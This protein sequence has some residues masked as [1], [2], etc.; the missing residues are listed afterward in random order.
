VKTSAVQE[1]PTTTEDSD[2]DS[3]IVHDPADDSTLYAKVPQR[4]SSFL[5]ILGRKPETPVKKKRS[6]FDRW[7]K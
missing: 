3:L 6:I 7:K 1:L 5:E 2:H 4:N